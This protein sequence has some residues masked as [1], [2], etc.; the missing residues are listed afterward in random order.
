MSKRKSKVFLIIGILIIIATLAGCI[1]GVMSGTKWGY[2]SAA[3]FAFGMVNAM[4]VTFVVAFIGK[5]DTGNGRDNAA[6]KDRDKT[7]SKDR[8]NVASNGK[9]NAASNDSKNTF[10]NEKDTGSEKT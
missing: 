2:V 8:D 1:A 9:E 5:T 4:F 10:R 7:A 6:S 3:F